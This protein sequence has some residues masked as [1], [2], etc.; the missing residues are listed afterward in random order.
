MQ[1]SDLSTNPTVCERANPFEERLLCGGAEVVYKSDDCGM[2]CQKIMCW[3]E[4]S[5]LSSAAYPNSSL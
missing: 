2:A 4:S 1:S 3:L 5:A